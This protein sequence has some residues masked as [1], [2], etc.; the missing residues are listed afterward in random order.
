MERYIHRLLDSVLAQSYPVI[1]MYVI[2]DE[3]V[4]N[5]VKI[6]EDYIDKFEARGFSLQ[7]IHQE[8]A[9]QSNAIKKGLQFIKGKYLVW[10]DADDYYASDDAILEMVA[11]LENSSE[12]FKMVR[13]QERIVLDGSFKEIELRGIT[14]KEEEERSL[15]EDCL[16]G[17][18]GFFF[19]SGAYM[20]D[21]QALRLATNFDIYTNPDAGQ[22][23]QLLLPVLHEHRCKTILKPYYN[24]VR[25]KDSH[26][27]M[28]SASFEDI[29][30]RKLTYYETQIE[31]LKR[32]K[33]LSSDQL[34]RYKT[35]LKVFYA[36]I[37]FKLSISQNRRCKTKEYFET[38]KDYNS[39]TPKERF[40]FGLSK[41][42]W[43]LPLAIKIKR[44]LKNGRH[45]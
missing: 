1:E 42:K 6:V 22:N 28:G 32:I 41:A 25:R 29:E 3:S 16:F 21:V 44:M 8:H 30:K 43:I 23:W 17:K 35:D 19:A 24:V 10:P 36:H 9:G 37:L 31:T 18:N 13:T 14:A 34:D 7:C 27:R 26:S 15:F 20:L 40:F 38:L 2:D 5:S 4:D 12:E 39:E 11:T 45:L 33:G